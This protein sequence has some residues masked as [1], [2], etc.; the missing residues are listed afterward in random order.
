MPSLPWSSPLLP[1]SPPGYLSILGMPTVLPKHLFRLLMF[2]PGDEWE[3]IW[4]SICL[5]VLRHTVD[6]TGSWGLVKTS[7]GAAQKGCE[8]KIL[9]TGWTKPSLCCSGNR[10]FGEGSQG[11]EGSGN[12]IW[13]QKSRDGGSVPGLLNALGA[14]GL[15]GYTWQRL[16]QAG[17]RAGEL[18]HHGNRGLSCLYS[19]SHDAGGASFHT[20]ARVRVFCP[21]RHSLG[22]RAVD[23]EPSRGAQLRGFNAFSEVG[24]YWPNM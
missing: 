6:W 22:P 9:L 17:P 15:C 16:S 2:P 23:Q 4:W 24:D 10:R 5:L 11:S 8:W 7:T 19:E 1:H 3:E 21:K 14:Q 18:G 13:S 12:D 20:R